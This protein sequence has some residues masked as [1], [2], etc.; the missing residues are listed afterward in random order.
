MY[1]SETVEYEQEMQLSTE[2][3]QKAAGRQQTQLKGPIH[4]LPRGSAIKNISNP[5]NAVRHQQ[6]LQNKRSSTITLPC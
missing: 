6:N 4:R 3:W 1:R 5:T 2:S